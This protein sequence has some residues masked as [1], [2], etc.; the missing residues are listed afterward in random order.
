[1][2]SLFGERISKDQLQE[3]AGKGQAA[4][5]TRSEQAGKGASG[6]SETR[7]SDSERAPAVLIPFN[8]GVKFWQLRVNVE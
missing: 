7:A 8:L 1:M 2:E 5:L 6:I 4:V 3:Q